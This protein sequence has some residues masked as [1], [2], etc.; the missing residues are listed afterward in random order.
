MSE[1]KGRDFRGE[2]VLWAVRW[3]GCVAKSGGFVKG[4]RDLPREV[5]A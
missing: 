3:Y 5:E 4:L 2:I 1:F